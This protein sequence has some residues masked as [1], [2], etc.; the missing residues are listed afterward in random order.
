LK[1]KCDIPRSSFAFKFNLRRYIKAERELRLGAERAARDDLEARRIAEQERAKVGRC[2][3][4]LSN[5]SS[6]RL[7]LSA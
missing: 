2:R 5:P 3:M 7:E 6:T 4:T 1:R